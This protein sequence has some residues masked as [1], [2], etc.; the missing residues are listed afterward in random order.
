MECTETEAERG[1]RGRGARRDPWENRFDFF[2]Y[3]DN[4]EEAETMGKALGRR[5]TNLL[6]LKTDTRVQRKAAAPN[7]HTP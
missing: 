6:Q 2:A 7:T 5:V 3:W 4:R 1:R